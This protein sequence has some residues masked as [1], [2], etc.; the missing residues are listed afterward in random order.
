MSTNTLDLLADFIDEKF[1]NE[2]ISSTTNV[3]VVGMSGA[4]VD[5]VPALTFPTASE[6]FGV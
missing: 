6:I 3:V 2:I 5:L 4:D 1:N